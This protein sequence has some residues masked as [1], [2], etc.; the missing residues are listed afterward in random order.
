[1]FGQTFTPRMK[2]ALALGLSAVMAAGAVGCSQAETGSKGKS[3]KKATITV[4]NYDRGNIPAA[5]GTVEENRW[6]KWINER[7]PVTV[8]F[9][10]VARAEAVR[11]LNVM[12]ASGSAP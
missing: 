3:E 5:E 7:S 6:T 11:K 2:F 9:V 4:S 8:K 12:F 1:M 10:P